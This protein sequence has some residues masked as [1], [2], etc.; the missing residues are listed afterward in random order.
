MP[1]KLYKVHIR[2]SKKVIIDTGNELSS[3]ILIIKVV[4][5]GVDCHRYCLTFV[6]MIS[7]K[8]RKTRTHSDTQCYLQ[9]TK[10]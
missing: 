8:E 2:G 10:L 4:R 3:K 9:M 6:S 7:L 1:V 5:R